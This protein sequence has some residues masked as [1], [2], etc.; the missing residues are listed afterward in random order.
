[1]LAGELQIQHPHEAD[2]T[3]TRALTCESAVAVAAPAGQL[4]VKAVL[5]ASATDWALAWTLP[6]EAAQWKQATRQ[7]QSGCRTFYEQ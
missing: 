2:G 3:K 7:A 4:Q 1:M 6:A 5:M